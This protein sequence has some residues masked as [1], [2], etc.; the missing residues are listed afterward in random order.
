MAGARIRQPLNDTLT[1]TNAT[2]YAHAKTVVANANS[3]RDVVEGLRTPGGGLGAASTNAT[4]AARDV[5]GAIPHSLDVALLAAVRSG[6]DRNITVYL[7]EWDENP[8]IGVKVIEEQHQGA[9]RVRIVVS[10]PHDGRQ[11]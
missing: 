1:P 11:P 8:E 3:C 4:D 10:H 6:L 7:D 9:P 5:L 2:G